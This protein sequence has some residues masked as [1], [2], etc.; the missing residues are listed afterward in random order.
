MTKR[1]A[2]EAELHWE[3]TQVFRMDVHIPP[4]RVTRLQPMQ[5]HLE[6]S[7]RDT[8]LQARQILAYR[9]RELTG[10]VPELEA[11]FL[12]QNRR[13]LLPSYF[14]R[15]TTAATAG[16]LCACCARQRLSPTQIKRRCC[17]SECPE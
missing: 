17:H 7:A 5:I 2:A 16:Q 4:D 11:F 10:K 15:H 1:K 13:R 6:L 3:C 14:C 8:I 12:E 9:I